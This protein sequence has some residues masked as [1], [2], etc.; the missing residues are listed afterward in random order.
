VSTYVLEDHAA[1]VFSFDVNWCA[2]L[3]SLHA[4]ATREMASKVFHCPE[5]MISHLPA[6]PVLFRERERER[7]GGQS[8]YR[9]EGPRGSPEVKG[10]RFLDNGTGWW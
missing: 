6:P 2:N 10:P 5:D 1:S 9:L 3:V 4:K 7:G 8:R